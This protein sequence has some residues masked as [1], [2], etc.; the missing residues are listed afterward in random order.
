MRLSTSTNTRDYV[1]GSSVIVNSV[2]RELFFETA[3]SLPKEYFENVNFETTF[4]KSQ[5]TIND[6]LKKRTAALDPL[7]PSVCYVRS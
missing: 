6:I 3:P 2:H 4:S 5:C 7:P 1:K